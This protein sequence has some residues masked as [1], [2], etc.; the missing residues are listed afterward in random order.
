MTAVDVHEREVV[1]QELAAWAEQREAPA[2]SLDR[3]FE[4]IDGTDRGRADKQ[5]C[6]YLFPGLTAKPWH[7][8]Q[9]FGWTAEL[10]RA[11][12]QIKAEF[13]TQHGSGLTVHPESG[14]LAASGAWDTYHFY[15]M[16][17]SFDEHL[18]QCPATAAALRHVPGIASAGM[19]Y[20]SAMQPH[21]QVKP[22]SGFVNARIRCHLG[23][24]VPDGCWIRV[25]DQVGG[26][27]EGECI[28]FDDSFEHEV[29]IG[30]DGWRAVLLL[31]T[32]HPEL[33]EV[34]IE[35]LTHL[36]HTW[37]ELFA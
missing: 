18:A 10:E 13:L 19:A 28:V 36:M 15:R 5:G 21:T 3:L 17:E 12:P 6:F 7:D 34:E 1:R 14:Q 20:Y 25:G 30:P 31:D 22:H 29:E 37:R 24:V 8:K 9:E 23:L 4:G 33:T 11:F 32:W 35:G 26:W 16:A 27:T 2:G